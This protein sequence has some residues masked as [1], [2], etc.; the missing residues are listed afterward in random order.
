[1]TS[2]AITDH[3]AGGAEAGLLRRE[4]GSRWEIECDERL[5]VWSALHV[6]GTSSRYLVAAS[7]S[8]LLAKLR[9]VRP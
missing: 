4:Y 2:N 9:A 3:A 7:A 8:E 6:S 1:M 5:Q